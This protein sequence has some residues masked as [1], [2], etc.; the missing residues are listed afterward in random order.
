MG[1]VYAFPE[2][3]LAPEAE[4]DAF[5]RKL[6]EAI[7]TSTDGQAVSLRARIPL[8]NLAGERRALA[9]L[10]RLGGSVESG[11]VPATSPLFL[12]IETTGLGAGAGV[13][14]F[15]VGTATIRGTEL[16]VDQFFLP[17]PAG[18]ATLLATVVER[19]AAADLL[20]TF[21]GKSF[22][23]PMLEGR[24]AFQR[25]PYHS[26]QV[27]SDLLWPARRIWR[28]RLRHTSLAVLEA[29]VLDVSRRAD[30]PGYEVPARY[31]AF[32]REGRLDAISPVLLHNYRD[33]VSLV[34]LA[35]AIDQLL[36]SGG[37]CHLARCSDLI[38]LSSLHESLGDVGAAQECL[39]AALLV[40]TPTERI[41]AMYQL[42]LLARQTNQSERAIELLI[43]VLEHAPER[44]VAAAVELATLLERQRGDL[45]G[46][47]Q[48]ARR[49]HELSLRR[50]TRLA[51]HAPELLEK[52]IRRLEAKLARR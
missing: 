2:T 23:L 30:V 38:G 20:V 26:P 32:V 14:A 16:I 12:D 36:E 39:E 45:A 52:R 42:A 10:A 19:L 25:A 13:F 35:F 48:Y 50:A 47:L 6:A 34:R 5:A 21:N 3:Y 49:A 44:G 43:A 46:A 22:D 8:S 31:F 9:R 28:P 1:P 27:H 24:C 29:G 41:E 40:A 7:R 37:H 18:E 15:L 17:S 51:A 33:L 11:G 4:E